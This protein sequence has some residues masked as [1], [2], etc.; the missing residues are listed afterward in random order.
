MSYGNIVAL[1]FHGQSRQPVCHIIIIG[2][3]HDGLT[4]MLRKPDDG[5]Q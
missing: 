3:F 5:A 1:A 2:Q 4:K